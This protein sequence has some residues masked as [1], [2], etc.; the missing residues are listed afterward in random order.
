MN[1]SPAVSAQ[2]FLMFRVLLLRISCQHLT[3]LWP[4]MV[5]ELVNILKNFQHQP[6]QSN[7]CNNHLL[8]FFFFVLFFSDSHIC[9]SRESSAGRK[10]C[11]K[12]SSH[13]FLNLRI[14][15]M[16]LQVTAIYTYIYT[17][18]NC[19]PRLSKVVRGAFDRNA[20]VNFSQ[21]ELDM[22]LSACKF[23]DTSLAFPPERI[24]LFQM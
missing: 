16:S 14:L 3:S 19:V 13:F 6:I 17:V 5:T 11:L 18:N 12:V 2:I 8:V 20:P 1:P 10:R 15:I 9:T 4:I 24:P 7:N 23:L 22:Y 21:A